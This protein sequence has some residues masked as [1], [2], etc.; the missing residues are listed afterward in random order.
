[1]K[2]PLPRCVFV[3]CLCCANVFAQV[4]DKEPAAVVELGGA[5]GRNVKEGGSSLSPTTAIEVTPI[6]NWL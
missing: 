3:F 1:M 2:R 5:V 4:D 6:E